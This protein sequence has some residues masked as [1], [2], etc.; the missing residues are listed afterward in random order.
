[1]IKADMHIHSSEDLIDSIDYKAKDIIDKAAKNGFSILSF[2]FHNC[3][4][5]DNGLA[6]YAKKKGILLIPG[7]EVRLKEGEVLIYYAG[8]SWP[9]RFKNNFF[10]KITDLD[11]LR[12]L[13]E[14]ERKMLIIA[15]HPYFFLEPCLGK[16]LEKN[17][18]LFDAIEFS[19]FYSSL[20]DRNR[21]AVIVAKRSGK[22]LIATS[23]CHSINYFGRCYS[24]ISSKKNI[25]CVFSAIRKGDIRICSKPLSTFHLFY[26]ATK[27]LFEKAIH[28][29]K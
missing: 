10:A 6:I 20:V 12:R 14:K 18:D 29:L 7:A 23:D 28:K 22:P 15:P 2:T 11:G 5:W 21:Q 19:W 1:M 16:E 9:D 26:Y 25:P 27:I 17:I 13:K 24:L 4:F 3:F 8:K